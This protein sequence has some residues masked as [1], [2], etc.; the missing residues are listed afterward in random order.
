[1]SIDELCM[2]QERWALEMLGRLGAL[3][4]CIHHDGVYVDEGVD[5]SEIYK[6]AMVAYKNSNGGSPFESVR[7][8]TDS[9]KIAYEEHGGNDVCPHCYRHADD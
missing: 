9:V 4:P 2:K 7:E 5:E 6:Y 1:M 3:S 8:M